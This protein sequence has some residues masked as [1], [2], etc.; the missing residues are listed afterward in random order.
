M[1][2]K[3]TRISCYFAPSD[4]A[5]LKQ[6]ATRTKMDASDHMRRALK[7]YLDRVEAFRNQAQPAPPNAPMQ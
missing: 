6:H 2:E 4:L 5:R 1:L 3:M 7:S